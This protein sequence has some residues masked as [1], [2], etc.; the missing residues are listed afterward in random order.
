MYKEVYFIKPSNTVTDKK[1][2]APTSIEVAKEA[3]VSQSTVSRVYNKKWENRIKEDTKK[4]VLK[5]AER[6]GYNP[7]AIA[8]GLTSRHTNIIGIVISDKFNVFYYSILNKLTNLLQNEGMR[9]MVFNTPPDNDLNHI[10]RRFLEYQVDGVIVTSSALTHQISSLLIDKAPPMVLINSQS[11]NAHCNTVY[12]DNYGA[13]RKVAE[14]LCET[15]HKSFAYISSSKS[16]HSNHETRQNGFLQGLKDHGVNECLI[17]PGDYS[18]E[19]GK[20]AGDI[21]FSEAKIPD[22]VFCANDRMAMG[23][24]DSARYKYKLRVPE[25]I[26]VIGFDDSET[27]SQEPYQ[28]TAISQRVDDMAEHTIKLLLNSM[29]NPEI[30]PQKICEPMDFIIR[31]STKNR[32]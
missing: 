10:L 26:S 7:N 17:V 20:A 14:Y 24:I 18:Y 25:D 16:L 31:S 28:L 3:G 19:S 9:T 15:G 4:K 21:L 1:S 8:R 23:I 11:E 27:V 29:K 13:C 12:C 5:A 6:L 22:A 2:Q 30:P 32:I